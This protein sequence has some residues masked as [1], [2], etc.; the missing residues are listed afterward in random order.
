MT[1]GNFLW[2]LI[3]VVTAI[4]NLVSIIFSLRRK[5]PVSEELYREYLRKSE[6]ETMCAAFKNRFDALDNHNSDTH[7]KIFNLI[8]EEHESS[9]ES[10][11]K[12]TSDIQQHMNILHADL[13]VLE[14]GLGRV[15][16][17]L[18]DKGLK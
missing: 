16:G 9:T 18:E 1:E 3:V 2:M 10:I 7:V 13:R 12:M 17:S 6:H 14:R 5:P 11:R 8:R 4:A 15:E